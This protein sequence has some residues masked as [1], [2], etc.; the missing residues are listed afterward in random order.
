[1]SAGISQA[2]KKSESPERSSVGIC[3]LI[4]NKEQQCREQST[5]DWDELARLYR[6]LLDVYLGCIHRAHQ[7]QRFEQCAE[8]LTRMRL[9]GI[10]SFLDQLLHQNRSEDM[11]HYINFARER[12]SSIEQP[13]PALTAIWYE[14]LGHLGWYRMQVGGPTVAESLVWREYSRYLFHHAADISPER[15]E[16]QH[17]LGR[18]ER[19]D[20]LRQLFHYTK[21]LVCV[22]SSEPARNTIRQFFKA[23]RRPSMIN[24]FICSHG[25][26][27]SNDGKDE[28]TAFKNEFLD[29][30]GEGMRFLDEG[31]QQLVYIACCNLASM[32]DYGNPKTAMSL[33]NSTKSDPAHGSFLKLSHYAMLGSELAFDTLS[34]LLQKSADAATWPGIHTYLVFIRYLSGHPL[35]LEQVEAL[36]PWGAIVRFLNNLVKEVKKAEHDASRPPDKGATQPLPEDFLIRGHWWSQGYYPPG[37]F[38]GAPPEADRDNMEDS[39]TFHWRRMRLVSLGVC[40]HTMD[41]ARTGR[42]LCS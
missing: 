26:L 16:A 5:E 1:M 17:Y 24:N 10:Q 9:N 30:L 7:R 14:C 19:Q 4:E 22:F 34:I 40:L 15:G 27:F 6:E 41:N 11:L 36:I 33:A 37:F 18:L 25:F 42:P 35:I 13:A 8:L 20:G 23:Y 31:G 32:F 12:M 29:S 39:S 3:S 21:S 28:F 38:D 2:T